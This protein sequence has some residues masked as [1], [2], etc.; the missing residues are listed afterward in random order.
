MSTEVPSVLHSATDVDWTAGTSA[1]S[2]NQIDVNKEGSACVWVTPHSAFFSGMAPYENVALPVSMTGPDSIQLRLESSTTI[3]DTETTLDLVL[4]STAGYATEKA[5]FDLSGLA[6]NIRDMVEVAT[7]YN[8]GPGPIMLVESKINVDH[9]GACGQ[10][11]NLIIRL[12][13]ALDRRPID[14]RKRSDSNA[15][16]L[17]ESDS[18][19]TIILAYDN[20]D[21]FARDVYWTQDYIVRDDNNLLDSGDWVELT[22]NPCDIANQTSTVANKRFHIELRPEDGRGAFVERATPDIIDTV[23][24]LN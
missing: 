16:G 3:P 6:T 5:G 19:H 2:I 17:S 23:M 10:L 24:D 11:T 8:G 12:R 18:I 21:H 22:A 7:T 14:L 4:Y 15:N 1:T 13:Y 9:V 20:K